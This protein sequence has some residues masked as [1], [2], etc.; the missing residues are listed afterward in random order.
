M[1]EEKFM[2]R[3]HLLPAMLPL[4]FA[5]LLCSPSLVWAQSDAVQLVGSANTPGKT[6][7][8]KV[9]K[10]SETLV[11][12]VD[13]KGAARPIPVNEISA[14]AFGSEPSRL[15]RARVEASTGRLQSAL[16]NLKGVDKGGI[17]RDLIKQDLA[18]Y[19]AFC[20]AKL[21]IGGRGNKGP[22]YN[23]LF[24]F[25]KNNPH[26]FHYFEAVETLG[27]LSVAQGDHKQAAIF[28][29]LLKK[30]S[31][32]ETKSDILLAGSYLALKRIDDAEELY[33]K[34]IASKVASNYDVTQK[35]YAQVGKAICLAEKNN[36]QEGIKRVEK[37]IAE[38]DPKTD[39]L[40]FAKAYNALGACYLKQKPANQKEALMA[41]LHTHL[42]YR[43][44]AELHAEALY[45]LSLLFKQQ[46][47]TDQAAETKNMLSELYPGSV[48]NK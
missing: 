39:R 46:N 28:Y 42:L 31:W 48:W 5:A 19:T 32:N 25:V 41:Y 27:D 21:A 34:V 29:K 36:P 45:H 15:R 6:I 7:R 26:T 4:I 33:D 43:S 23:E 8:G 12:L 40:L 22:A 24:N 44:D 3:F 14:I 13:S 35:L 16:E 10:V 47:K 17:S 2:K 11:E 9:G 20:Q 30:V 37:V 18:F 1:F 38:N